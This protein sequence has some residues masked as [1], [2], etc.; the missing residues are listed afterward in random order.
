MTPRRQ[1]PKTSIG[2][3]R[4]HLAPRH[5]IWMTWKGSFLMGP[6]YL[7]FLEAVEEHGTILEAGRVV[8]WSYR[9]CL[10]RLRRME[11]VMGGVVLETQRGGRSGGGARLSPQASRLVRLFR[12]WERESERAIKASF[13]ATL[14]RS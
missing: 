6:N 4:P 8:G 11:K 14:G 9:T 13:V 12:R 3:L 2:P 1:E 10:N 5:K 7:K